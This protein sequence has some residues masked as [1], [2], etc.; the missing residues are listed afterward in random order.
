MSLMHSIG[1]PD[2]SFGGASQGGFTTR[3][4]PASGNIWGDYVAYNMGGQAFVPVGQP[5]VWRWVTPTMGHELWVRPSQGT[6]TA[7]IQ[8]FYVRALCHWLIDQL[9]ARAFEELIPSLVQMREFY[10]ASPP[11]EQPQLAS[12]RMPLAKI[13]VAPVREVELP[14][15]D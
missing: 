9:P 8:V 1:E 14:E 2:V 3:W 11:P 4:N 5:F 13:T 12:A 6:A 7:E 15:E 10:S